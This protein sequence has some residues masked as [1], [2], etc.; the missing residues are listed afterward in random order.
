MP[1]ELRF[2]RPDVVLEP[3]VDRFYASLLTLASD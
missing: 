3:L 1:D 2:L